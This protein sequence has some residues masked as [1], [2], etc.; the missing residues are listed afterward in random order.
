[1]NIVVYSR[2]KLSIAGQIFRVVGPIEILL[3]Y[4]ADPT[5]WTSHVSFDYNHSN[6]TNCCVS[7]FIDTQGA[8]R[9]VQGLKHP[10]CISSPT[11]GPLKQFLSTQLG[12]ALQTQQVRPQTLHYPK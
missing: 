6:L 12:V 11:Y 2:I 1:M 10:N 4:I 3:E 8:R 9:V 7:I 5:G